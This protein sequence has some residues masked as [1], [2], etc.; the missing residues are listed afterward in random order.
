V[1]PDLAQQFAAFQAALPGS[2]G[3][4]YLQQRGIPLALAQQLGVG[5][6]AP[7]TWPHAAR[8]WRSGRVV[9]AQTTP[10][11]CEVNL[12]GRAVGTAEQVPKAKRHDH[13]PGVKGYFNAAVL[14]SVRESS[15]RI[16][17]I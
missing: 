14:C 10:D 15:I 1:R 3:D 7:G 16:W 11:S 12:Y 4:T 2:C 13:L 5:Y 6:A 9:F 17:T 8:D